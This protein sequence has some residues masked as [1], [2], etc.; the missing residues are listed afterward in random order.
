MK[1]L[2]KDLEEI[3]YT[4]KELCCERG[5]YECFPSEKSFIARQQP[6][7]KYGVADLIVVDFNLHRPYFDLGVTTRRTLTIYIIEC[8]LNEVN[9]AAYLQAKRYKHAIREVTE[10]I[11]TRHT[12]VCIKTVLIGNS[13]DQTS[14]FVFQ[15]NDDPDCTAYTYKYGADGI[16]FDEVGKDWTL[17]NGITEE[18]KIRAR[19]SIWGMFQKVLKRKLAEEQEDREGYLEM[20]AERDLKEKLGKPLNN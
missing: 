18:F 16:W 12:A 9:I 6:L 2:E 1:F 19:G 13:V 7:G 14:D 10:R 3:I 8:K 4:Y 17:H 15:L 11:N 20:C 5:L